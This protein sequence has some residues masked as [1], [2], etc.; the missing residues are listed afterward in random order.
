MPN[1][2]E[3][4]TVAAVI[5]AL[6]G[7]GVTYVITHKIDGAKLAHVEQVNAQTLA[8]INAT[9]AQQLA[10][11]LKRGQAAEGKVATLE[12]QFDNEVAAHAKDNLDYRAKLLAGTASVRVHVTACHPASAA[13]KGTAAPGTVDDSAAY[14]EL[15]PTTAAS[16]FT[17]VDDADNT[18]L[19]LVKLQAYITELQDDGYISK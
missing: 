3:L 9:S 1:E 13:G 12:Q 18:A 2:L 16:A 4:C 17:V 10:D 6:L 11:A 19:K 8:K 7:G 15:S 14:A 5:G